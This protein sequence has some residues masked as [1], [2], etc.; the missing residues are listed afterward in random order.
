M[1]LVLTGFSQDV[2]LDNPDNVQYHLNLKTPEG[3][4]VRLPVQKETTEALIIA[5]YDQKPGKVNHTPTEEDELVDEEGTTPEVREPDDTNM[6]TTF[7]MPEGQELTGDPDLDG[8][9]LL[10]APVPQQ[11]P[12]VVEEEPEPEEEYEETVPDSEDEIPSL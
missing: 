9:N 1:N 12:Q 2:D 10:D 6:G 7:Q 8:P 3:K 4:V 5:V 11:A